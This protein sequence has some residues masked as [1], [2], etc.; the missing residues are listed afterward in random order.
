MLMLDYHSV[1][2]QSFFKYTV[3]YEMILLQCLIYH[4]T[5]TIG[6]IFS[7]MLFPIKIELN[8]YQFYNS[9]LKIFFFNL[10]FIPALAR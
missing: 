10:I 3:I 9:L 4:I 1:Q 2:L 6:I 8:E 7:S 5:S